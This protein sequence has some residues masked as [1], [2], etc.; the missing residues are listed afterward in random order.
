MN[1]TFNSQ[2]NVD[3]GLVQMMCILF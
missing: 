3:L 1:N 2:V